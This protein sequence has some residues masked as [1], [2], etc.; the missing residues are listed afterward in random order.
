[1]LFRPFT[2]FVTWVVRL[3]ERVGAVRL[4]V[5]GYALYAALGWVLLALPI[6]HEPGAE[7]NAMDALFTA[8]SALSTTGLS[9]VDTP[10]AYS[11]FGEAVI[12]LLIQAGG[13]GYMTLGS[14][15]ALSARREMSPLRAEIGRLTFTLPAGFEIAPFVRAV[16]LYTF[17]IESLGTAALWGAFR[18]AGVESPLWHAVFHSISSFCTAGFSTFPDSLASFRDDFWV[19]AIVGVLSVAGAVGFIVVVDAAR[20]LTG[21]T[22]SMT[23]TSRIIVVGTLISIVGGTALLWLSDPGLR[24][25]PPEKALMAAGFQ[26]MT[27]A[28]TVGFNTVDIGHLSDA[29][30][31]VT[32]ILMIVGASPSGTGG[33]IKTTTVSAMLGQVSAALRSRSIV[34]FWGRPIPLERVRAASAAATC[35]IVTLALATLAMQIV[36]HHAFADVFFEAAS[37]LGTVG[38]SRGITGDLSP[39][40]EVI[41]IALMFVGRVGPLTIGT[42]MFLAAD[43]GPGDSDLAV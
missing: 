40:A 41:V 14:F 16:C 5:L 1:M 36:D 13:L 34:T 32:A 10:G 7:V 2:R 22:C 26:A 27:A 25:L 42:A 19:N 15:I 6:A 8:V 23:I 20:R 29:A 43:R 3:S 30:V 37:A 28:T 33:G 31:T 4:L 21:R 38:L 18:H 39:L 9:T 12:L 35:Y 24:E 17:A 11:S